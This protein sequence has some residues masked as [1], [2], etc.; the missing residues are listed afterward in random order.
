M[1][2]VL[3]VS[4]SQSLLRRNTSLLENQGFQF[5][6]ASS[7]RE[8]FTLHAKINFDLILCDMELE[9]MDGCRFCDEVRK[10]PDSAQLPVVFIC[11]DTAESIKKA[12][13][14][15]A[16]AILLRPVNPT[17]LLITIGSFIGMQLARSKRVVFDAPVLIGTENV[18]LF[19]SAR[20]IS[21]SGV[22]IE[23][24]HHLDIG[25]SITCQFVLP[26]IG[27]IKPAG[28]VVRCFRSTDGRMRYGSKFID[29][30]PAGRRAIEQYVVMHGDQG[31]TPIVSHQLERSSWISKEAGFAAKKP[32][33]GH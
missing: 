28:E 32:L 29:L 13:Q 12:K 33:P 25:S 1:K 19:C 16:N 31:V 17:H 15:D 11:Y 24:E 21:I 9:D 5:F 4:A 22:L 30:S 7:G 14:G 3:L 26:G 10:L 6:T 8:S 18:T 23:T 20:D 27:E 2:K